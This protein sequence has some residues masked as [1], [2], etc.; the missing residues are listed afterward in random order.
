MKRDLSSLSGQALIYSATGIAARAIA[1]LLLPVYTRLLSP[2]EFGIWGVALAAANC[3][4]LLLLFGL[5]TPVSRLYFDPADETERRRLYG[6]LFLLQLVGG[7]LVAGAF[8]QVLARWN[9]LANV[10]SSTPLRLALWT[11][12]V[13]NLGLIPL[14][15]MRIRQQAG[16]F[17]LVS[18]LAGLVTGLA[19]VLVLIASER[20]AISV[21]IG[22]L[23]G[24]LLM[25]VVYTLLLMPDVSLFF[26]WRLA[27]RTLAYSLQFV[28]H[29]LASWVLSLSDRFILE[30][31]AP[32]DRVGVYTVGYSLAFSLMFVIEGVGQSWLPFFLISEHEKTHRAEIV[33]YAT[34]FVTA[35]SWVAL[36][37]A[38]W[39]PLFIRWVLPAAYADSEGVFVI[40]T[41]GILCVA[42][43]LLFSLAIMSLKRVTVMPLITVAVGGI[44]VVLNF[45]WIPRWGIAAAAA[46][47]TASYGLLA[48][49]NYLLARRI[50]PIAHDYRRWWMALGSTFALTAL[51]ALP[52]LPPLLDLLW[53]LAVWSAWPLGLFAMR[54]FSPEELTQLR[55]IARRIHR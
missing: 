46:T 40:V 29:S 52:V 25:A 6:T 16:R 12:W 34:Y 30:R 42:P 43:H 13:G 32:L 8:D 44:N 48:L 7:F 14:A 2:E 37:M 31:L 28:P 36:S 53:R 15:L 47:T 20:S 49:G 1:F 27:G 54:F 26:S 50:Y 9:I 33:R 35:V 45:W 11:V 23:A 24:A 10:P 22:S 5:D 51:S 17:A 21:L 38:I 19:P 4:S 3:F 41:L 39:G 55:S 18:T